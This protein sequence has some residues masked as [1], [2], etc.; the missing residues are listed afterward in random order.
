MLLLWSACVKEDVYF[1]PAADKAQWQKKR[2]ASM[3]WCDIYA[4][5]NYQFCP[6][7]TFQ[8]P[9][10]GTLSC[11]RWLVLRL[12]TSFIP[13][14]IMSS[15]QAVITKAA[16]QKWEGGSRT[17]TE[18]KHRSLFCAFAFSNKL[19]GSVFYPK[20]DCDLTQYVNIGAKCSWKKLRTVNW[21]GVKTATRKHLWGKQCLL[22]L[23]DGS[24]VHA[25]VRRRRRRRPVG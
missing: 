18:P 20:L 5:C 21:D 6:A 12:L 4:G 10:T 8:Q 9:L 22:V 15:A 17:R 13:S 7:I 1:N 25:P 23:V 16:E 14:S 24:N 2:A 19:E 3:G 11:A